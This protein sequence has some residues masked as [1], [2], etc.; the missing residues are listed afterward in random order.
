[1]A[2]AV[3]LARKQDLDRLAE[4]FLLLLEE[5]E[6]H[7][8]SLAPGADAQ[9]GLRGLLAWRL[10]RPEAQVLVAER[11]ADEAASQLLGFCVAGLAH[12]PPIFR[13]KLRGEIEYLFVRAD[14]RRGGVGSALVG[15]ALDWLA[16][17]GVP[18]VALQVARRNRAGLAFWRAFRFEPVMDVLERAL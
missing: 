7:D 18:R 10:G 3:R 16:R 1:M 5:Q 13:E 2:V 4:L 12:R 14:A 15:R 17:Q 6:A 9:E 8:P 11:V